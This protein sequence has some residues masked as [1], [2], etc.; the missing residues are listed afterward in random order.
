MAKKNPKVSPQ[1]AERDYMKGAEELHEVMEK[2]LHNKKGDIPMKEMAK[3]KGKK[4]KKERGM[5]I[6]IE[7]EMGKGKKKPMPKKSNLKSKMPKV[8]KEFR[9]GKLHSG[10][11]KGP[12]V[13]NP[14]Q[15]L[16]ISYSEARQAKKK[17]K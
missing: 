17:K 12:V 2:K 1:K 15:A 16:A 8:M 14:K 3:H 7:I 5:E 11:K 9:E 10:S 4:P 6:E 13:T